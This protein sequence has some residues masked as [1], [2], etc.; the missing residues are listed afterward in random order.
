MEIILSKEQRG[1]GRSLRQ[2]PAAN[3]GVAIEQLVRY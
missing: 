1:R 2:I 3:V